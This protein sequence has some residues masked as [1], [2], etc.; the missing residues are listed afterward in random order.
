MYTTARHWARVRAT[1]SRFR[2]RTKE[3]LGPGNKIKLYSSTSIYLS[4]YLSIYISISVSVCLSVC[5]SLSLYIY[6][7]IYIYNMYICIYMYHSKALGACESDVKSIE[8]E[9]E[10]EPAAAAVSG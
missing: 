5:L 3:R 2:L 1:L 10:R 8:V 6:I 7:Y 4:I 9:N